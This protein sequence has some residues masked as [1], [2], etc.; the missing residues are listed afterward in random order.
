MRMNRS[1]RNV[2]PLRVGL[3]QRN[4]DQLEDLHL[5][6]PA[7]IV[8]K[9]APSHETIAAVK[10]WLIDS[11]LA[12][13]RLRLSPSCGW[14]TAVLETNETDRIFFGHAEL[15]RIG[16]HNYSVPA[17]VR[18][19]VDLIKPTVQFNQR[20]P[21]PKMNK[22]SLNTHP[23]PTI[24]TNGIEGNKPTSLETCDETITPDCL[25]ALYNFHYTPRATEK[26][27]FGIVEFTPNAFLGSDLDLFFGHI[28]GTS[29][30]VKSGKGPSKF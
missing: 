16:C 10:D 2:I 26:N 21:S 19:H 1:Y 29:H 28:S 4:L 13:D 30:Q 7:Q 3:R 9:F 23:V 22:R 24:Q 14:I 11:G 6:S 25:R 5:S 12:S 20:A 15:G 18:D 17:A 8:D 27:T